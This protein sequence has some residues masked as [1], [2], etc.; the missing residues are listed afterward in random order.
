MSAGCATQQVPRLIKGEEGLSEL[1]QQNAPPAPPAAGAVAR[2]PGDP[3]EAAPPAPAD[4]TSSPAGPGGAAGNR[5]G[6]N[7]IAT[8]HVQEGPAARGTAERNLRNATNPEPVPVPLVTPP[9]S[10]EY[11]IDLATALR[12]ADMVN[13]TINRA[14]TVILEALGAPVDGPDAARALA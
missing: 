4:A 5:P 8:V 13:P 10:G 6:G 14:R 7:V 3:S 1:K 9:P 2:P 12:L 11:P